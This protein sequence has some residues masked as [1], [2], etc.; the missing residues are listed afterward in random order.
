MFTNL[1]VIQNKIIILIFH[2]Q[3]VIIIKKIFLVIA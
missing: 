2:K 1:Y 3:S